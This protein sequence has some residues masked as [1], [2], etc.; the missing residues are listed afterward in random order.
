MGMIY[1]GTFAFLPLPHYIS[2]VHLN[3]R[4]CKIIFFFEHTKNLDKQLFRTFRSNDDK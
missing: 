3:P 4:S 2:L 1:S